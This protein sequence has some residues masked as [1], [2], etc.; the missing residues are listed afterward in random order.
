[1]NVDVGDDV[2]GFFATKGPAGSRLQA[3]HHPRR[4][5][6]LFDRHTEHAGDA[7][8][9]ALLQSVDVIGDQRANQRLLDAQRIDLQ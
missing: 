5:G 2:D 4:D 7:A 1:M 6:H 9:V 3:S 8:E